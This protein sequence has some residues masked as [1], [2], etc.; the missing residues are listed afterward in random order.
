M[1]AC[2]LFHPPPFRHIRLN[3]NL[4]PT[5]GSGALSKCTAVAQP[6]RL[7]YCSIGT[8]LLGAV[9][10]HKIQNASDVVSPRSNIIVYT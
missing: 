1:I 3:N 6:S 10:Y 9:R 2:E 8:L 5:L 4:E 7:W